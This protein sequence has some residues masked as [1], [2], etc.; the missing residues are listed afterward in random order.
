M[1]TDRTSQGRLRWCWSVKQEAEDGEADPTHD[2]EDEVEGPK[3]ASRAREAEGKMEQEPERA[4]AKERCGLDTWEGSDSGVARDGSTPMPPSISLCS[5]R[6]LCRS[7]L[8][9]GNNSSSP[10]CTRLVPSCPLS[11]NMEKREIV[12]SSIGCTSLQSGWF[13]RVDPLCR[14]HTGNPWKGQVGGL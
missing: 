11:G 7:S 1:S 2:F 5:R 6:V 9:H 4:S 3:L 13:T 12:R 10:L 8:K 14:I